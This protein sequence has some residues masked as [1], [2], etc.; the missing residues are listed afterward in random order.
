MEKLMLKIRII[1]DLILS[2]CLGYIALTVSFPAV[3]VNIILLVCSVFVLFQ[4]CGNIDKENHYGKYNQDNDSMGEIS[5]DN[6]E[7]NNPA[8]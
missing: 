6:N 7:E 3:L 4:A 2:I 8:K 5:M 1:G